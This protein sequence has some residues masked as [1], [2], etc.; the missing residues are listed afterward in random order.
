M[1]RCTMCGKK[2]DAVDVYG[3]FSFQHRVGYGSKHD[4]DMVCLTLC[5]DCFDRIIDIISMMSKERILFSPQEL[6]KNH[7]YY[8]KLVKVRGRYSPLTDHIGRQSRPFGGFSTCKN[9][10]SAVYQK[11]GKYERKQTKIFVLA[12]AFLG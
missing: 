8:G 5:S 9:K 1:K 6:S 10:K 7:G 4:G 12:G 11:R 3:N 2:L